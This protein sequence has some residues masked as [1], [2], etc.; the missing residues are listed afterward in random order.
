VKK[1]HDLK[2]KGAV[3][4]RSTIRF[5]GYL[6]F[7][8]YKAACDIQTA[9]KNYR[10]RK[11][12]RFFRNIVRNLKALRLFGKYAV[13]E[14]GRIRRRKAEI[15]S[16]SHEEYLTRKYFADVIQNKINYLKAFE[17]KEKK[18]K[19]KSAEDKALHER[20]CIYI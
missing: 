6:R 11:A 10:S 15:K 4:S 9:Y 18:K 3:V 7:K 17:L 8:K 19:K 1:V 5:V 16:M 2:L 13:R 12:M 14:A 20:R